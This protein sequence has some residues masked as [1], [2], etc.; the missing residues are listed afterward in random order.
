MTIALLAT[1]D[2]IILGDTLNTTSQ[3]LAHGLNSEGLVMGFHLSSSDKES[4]IV[5]CLTFLT[6]THDIVIITGGLGPTSDDRTRFALSQFTQT[7][8]I[9]F[10]EALQHIETRLRHSK[11]ALTEGNRQQAKFPPGSELLPNPNGTAVGCFYKHNNKLFFLLPGP[12]REC[13]PMF[14]NYVLP[15][16]QKT[17]RHNTH[18]L[19]WRLFGVAESQIAQQ[20]DTAL[21]HLDC[22]T[23][24][25]LETPYVE[26]KVRCRPD[27]LA[28]VTTIVEPIVSPHIIA[29]TEKKASE[30]LYEAILRLQTRVTI[31]DDVTGGILQTLLQHPDSYDLISFHDNSSHKLQFHLQGLK[32]FWSQQPRVGTTTLSIHVKHPQGDITET[33]ELPYRS[34]LVVHYAAEW[35]SF[36][37][38]HLINQLH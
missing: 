32:E 2:E 25:R 24:Y 8:L 7:P 29:S 19:K 10:P 18:L 23:G 14:N 38:F 16:L 27:L 1:G 30:M 9:L 33:H 11:L 36:R 37:L 20:L 21:K 6:R 13:L 26:C 22:E 15:R 34:P 5:D 31:L 12:P 35:L 4:D 3:Q 28:A 17:H